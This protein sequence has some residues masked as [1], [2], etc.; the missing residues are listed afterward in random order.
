MIEP[1]TAGL[2]SIAPDGRT[3]PVPSEAQRDA[4]FGRI[5]DAVKAHSGSVV[6]V[7]GLG[8]VGVAV[9]AALADSGR[10]LV[11]GVDLPAPSSY[12]KVGGVAAGSTSLGAS[13]ESL[14]VA[15][16]EGVRGGRLFATTVEEAYALADVIVVDVDLGLESDGEAAVASF[17]RAIRGVGAHM[18]EDAL[19]VVETTVPVGTCRTIVL[20]ALIDER[21]RRGIDHAPALANAYERV[22]PGPTYLDSVRRYPRSFAGVDADSGRRARSFLE[23]YVDAPLHEL[24]DLESAELGKLLENSY[25]S[26]NIAF[27]HEWTKLAESIGVDLWAVVD[28]IRARRGT[29]DN[30]R[31]PGFGVGGYCLTKD[32]LLAQ[33]GAERLLGSDVR[34]EATLAALETNA[35]MPLH[36]LQLLVELSGGTLDGKAVALCGIAYLAGVADTRNSPSETFVR[37][38]QAAGAE[39]RVHDPYVVRWTERPDI[40]MHQELADTLAGV[41]AVVLAVPHRDYTALDARTLIAMVG[42]PALLVDAQNIVGDASARKLRD[43]GWRLAGVGKGHWR[44]AGYGDPL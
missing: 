12:W 8:F 31:N 3:Y 42:S 23:S 9:C 10:H 11:I 28:S 5:A 1:A 14:V 29:H 13:D 39:V 40:D 18:R 19:V 33:W 17:E 22:M 41:D 27:I 36:T 16:A 38:L 15:L 26:A 32:S 21:R 30:I 20:P 44:A 34:L 43:A 2:V 37:E 35:V 25:R 4:E 24:P 7:Q 6:A